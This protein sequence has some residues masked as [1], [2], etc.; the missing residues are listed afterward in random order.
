MQGDMVQA[1]R[2]FAGTRIIVTMSY[3]FS[4]FSER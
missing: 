2:V 1:V 4:Q 3:E